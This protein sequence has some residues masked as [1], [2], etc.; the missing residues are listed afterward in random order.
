MVVLIQTLITKQD[1]WSVR[2]CA[3]SGCV[4]SVLH[5]TQCAQHDMAFHWD[6]CGLNQLPLDDEWREHFSCICGL[7]WHSLWISCAF[8][9]IRFQATVARHVC[10][11]SPRSICHHSDDICIEITYSLQC[12]IPAVENISSLLYIKILRDDEGWIQAAADSFLLWTWWK[13]FANRSFSMSYI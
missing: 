11:S 6:Y 13:Y 9:S 5:P 12:I 3:D 10:S 1:V 2:I 7:F 4:V 8:L